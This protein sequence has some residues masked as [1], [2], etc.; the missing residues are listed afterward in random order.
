M[1]VLCMVLYVKLKAA[2]EKKPTVC[3]GGLLWGCKSCQSLEFDVLALVIPQIG[4]LLRGCLHNNSIR[5]KHKGIVEFWS[6]VY[7]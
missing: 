6:L 3:V 1:C 4:L 2:Q 7:T 5:V